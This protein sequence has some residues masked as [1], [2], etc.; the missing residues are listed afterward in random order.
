MG[1]V[2]L[3]VVCN[4]DFSL[5]L[6]LG[7]SLGLSRSGR[8]GRSRW[9]RRRRW[10]SRCCGLLNLFFDQFTVIGREETSLARSIRSGPP[11]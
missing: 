4:H 9:S 7:S 6:L 5:F 2:S 11:A 1:D 8:W 10:R 3:L